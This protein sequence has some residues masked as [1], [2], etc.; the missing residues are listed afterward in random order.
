MVDCN[1]VQNPIVPRTKL[2]K[3]TEGQKV[4]STHFKKIV[5]SLMY[6]TNTRPDLMYVVSLISKFMESPTKVHLQTTK[7]IL[8]Y[9]KGTTYYGLFYKKGLKGDFLLGYSDSDYAGDLDDRKS[10]S[11]YVFMYGSA[12]VPWSSKKQPVVT[13]STTKAEFIAAASCTC[14]AVRLRRLLN[15]LHCS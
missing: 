3:D 5:R 8:R 1:V 2:I 4:D 11:G 7:R 13:L 15:E 10:T 6:L 12:V 14:Q 9:V